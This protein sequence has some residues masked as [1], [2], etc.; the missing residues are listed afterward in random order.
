[1]YIFF[2]QTSTL[3]LPTLHAKYCTVLWTPKSSNGLGSSSLIPYKGCL[4]KVNE[5]PESVVWF[6]S[7]CR[8][9]KSDS[10][11]PLMHIYLC[12]H[13]KSFHFRSSRFHLPCSNPITWPPPPLLAHLFPLSLP[14]PFLDHFASFNLSFLCLTTGKCELLPKLLVSV[15]HICVQT[16]IYIAIT[17][18]ISFCLY[19]NWITVQPASTFV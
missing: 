3:C 4:C 14:C 19:P 10:I 11:H 16:F 9:P 13:G 7:K 6:H 18:F 17:D 1:M 8:K 15:S 5:V 12:M 2:N